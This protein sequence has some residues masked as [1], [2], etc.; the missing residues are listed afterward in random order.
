M[1]ALGKTALQRRNWLSYLTDART[2][3]SLHWHQAEKSAVPSLR[4]PSGTEA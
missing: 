3:I 1:T 2:Q 4:H